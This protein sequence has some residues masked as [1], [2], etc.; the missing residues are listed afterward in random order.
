MTD[1]FLTVTY[2]TFKLSKTVI[3]TQPYIRTQDSSID[4]YNT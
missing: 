3:N 2:T 1:Y 4:D